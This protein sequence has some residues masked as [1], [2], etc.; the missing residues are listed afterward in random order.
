VTLQKQHSD[1]QVIVWV[2]PIT[3]R[4]RLQRMIIDT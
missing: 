3:N 4:V 2:W 1:D